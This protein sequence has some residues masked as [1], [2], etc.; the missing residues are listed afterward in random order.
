MIQLLLVGQALLSII[1][2]WII[3]GIPRTCLLVLIKT[4]LLPSLQ[5]RS[6]VFQISIFILLNWTLCPDGCFY[7][8]FKS[9]QN[10]F[11]LYNPCRDFFSPFPSAYLKWVQ[12]CCPDSHLFEPHILMSK[13]LPVLL[14][15]NDT[16]RIFLSDLKSTEWSH[17]FLEAWW[18]WYWF[19]YELLSF[20]NSHGV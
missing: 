18:M 20:E 12:G 9:L 19:K 6:S 3:A 13:I 2:C 8:F 15:S 10:N 7:I 5:S 16:G 1:P 4:K 17:I 14:M 11:S